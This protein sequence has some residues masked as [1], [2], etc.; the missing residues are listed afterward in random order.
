MTT[1]H[2]LSG[3]P[4][5]YKALVLAYINTQ[6]E[7]YVHDDFLNY[8]KG[9]VGV[10]E[11]ALG[12]QVSFEALSDVHKRALWMLFN[13]T[14]RS[15]LRT[16]TPWD[17]FLD[18]SL[19][20]V[21]LE[22]MGENGAVVFRAS[23]RIGELASASREQHLALLYTLFEC[24]FGRPAVVLTSNQLREYGFDDSKEPKI[25]DYYDYI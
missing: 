10:L 11:T 22:K 7:H 2:R 14:V 1:I 17:N 8:Y 5:D 15:Y 9:L 4:Y 12:V 21:S 3:K 13:S 16:G 25:E 23:E 24:M 18:E 19:V 6:H 20:V